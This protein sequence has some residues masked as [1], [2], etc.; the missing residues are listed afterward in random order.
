MR[1]FPLSISAR[2]NGQTKGELGGQ[3][4]MRCGSPPAIN[5]ADFNN[6]LFAFCS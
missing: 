5:N 3:V 2:G 4:A 6:G 1:M